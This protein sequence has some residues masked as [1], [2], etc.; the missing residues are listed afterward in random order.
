MTYSLIGGD[1]RDQDSV[2]NQINQNIAQLKVDEQTKIVKDD[3][4]TRRILLGKGKNGFYGL[5]ISQE[6]TDVYDGDDL[7]MVFNSDN[8]LFKIVDS[9]TVTLTGGTVAANDT[10]AFTSPLI[11]HS[12]GEPPVVLAFYGS[13]EILAPWGG[14]KIDTWSDV[15]T[16]FEIIRFYSQIIESTAT[17]VQ[18]QVLFKNAEG[19]TTTF[20]DILIKYF[21]L[22]ETLS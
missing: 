15:G 17:T 4:G 11:N 2:I 8:N 22:Q 13:D 5:K 16:H 10:T 20:D 3:A 1:T 18:F 21:I 19:S 12:V 6:G 9:G 7:D 14:D